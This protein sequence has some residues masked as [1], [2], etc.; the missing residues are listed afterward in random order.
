MKVLFALVSF[1]LLL[2]LT[3]RV[4]SQSANFSV[5]VQVGTT[6][7]ILEGYT[8]PN[9][10]VSFVEGVTTVATTSSDAVGFFTTTLSSYNI[11]ERTIIISSTD[12][13]NRTT[14][15]ASYTVTLVPGTDTTLSNIILSPTFSV[16][17]TTMYSESDSII[18]T[19]RAVPN[20]QIQFFIDSIYN[21]SITASST[22]TFT[23]Q[24][25]PTTMSVGTH[26]FYLKGVV[27]AYE[28]AA[29][30]SQSFTIVQSTEP[31]DDDEDDDDGDDE[32][33]G[34]DGD[35]DTSDQDEPTTYAKPIP[36]ILPTYPGVFQPPLAPQLTDDAKNIFLTDKLTADNIAEYVELW[37]KYRNLGTLQCDLNNDNICDLVDFSI[38]MYRVG[39]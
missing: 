22:G 21:S 3:G 29:S 20:A 38:L 13:E 36:P 39:R 23:V 37:V 6:N 14:T 1:S 4:Y 15:G 16:N 5:S 17:K 28:S 2:I 10:F 35:D 30:P 34:D 26:T 31:D 9:A 25:Y 19:G 12:A 11:T 8:S 32:D 7:L 18:V 33:D 27:G 24:L